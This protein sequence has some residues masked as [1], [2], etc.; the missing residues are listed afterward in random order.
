MEEKTGWREQN[1]SQIEEEEKWQTCWCC[2]DQQSACRMARASAEK[3]AHT[4]PAVKEKSDLSATERA[5]G[6]N[7]RAIFAKRER[8]KAVCPEYQIVR[9][10]FSVREVKRPAAEERKKDKYF[11]A[12]GQ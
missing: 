10:E 4:G 12:E 7:A 1:E 5:V 8:N 2:R 9:R 11:S 3:L 6:K